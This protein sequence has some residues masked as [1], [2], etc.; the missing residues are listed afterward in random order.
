MSALAQKARS[1]HILGDVRLYANSGHRLISVRTSKS[2]RFIDT[3]PLQLY[4]GPD[5]RCDN[6]NRNKTPDAASSNPPAKIR[7]APATP[8]ASR[9]MPPIGVKT[10]RPA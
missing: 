9:R 7:A 4:A 1:A 3:R 10:A 2:A 6:R 8:L 5:R